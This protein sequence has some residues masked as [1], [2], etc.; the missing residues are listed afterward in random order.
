MQLYAG[1]WYVRLYDVLMIRVRSPVDLGVYLNQRPL[2]IAELETIVVQN[3]FR[4]G[5]AT[6]VQYISYFIENCT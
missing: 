1:P 3:I 4:L 6:Q 2:Q 5:H